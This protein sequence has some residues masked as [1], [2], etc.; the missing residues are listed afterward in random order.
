MVRPLS[1]K[2]AQKSHKSIYF[3]LNF[4]INLL[5]Y[6]R[7][8]PMPNVGDL[9]T[10]LNHRPSKKKY[11][12]WQAEPPLLKFHID[13]GGRGPSPTYNFC[14]LDNLKREC[15]LELH[16]QKVVQKP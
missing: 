16:L 11:W 15:S 10:I 4:K 6:C 9:A 5:P 12:K 3:K 14:T 2:A 13:L 8:L 7:F 1:T